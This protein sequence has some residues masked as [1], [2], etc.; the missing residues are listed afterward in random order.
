MAA[1]SDYQAIVDT[2]WEIIYR[3]L[4]TIKKTGTKVNF[5]SEIWWLSG[6]L[7][8]IFSLVVMLSQ[9]I[10]GGLFRLLMEWSNQLTPTF[11]GSI[12]I[13]VG[14]L[15]RSKLVVKLRVSWGKDMHITP[16]LG[17]KTVHQ[18]SWGV[19]MVPSW[20]QNGQVGMVKLSPEGVPL[21]W[22][23]WY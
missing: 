16:L 1:V 12:T 13:L 6:S 15:R 4:E 22:N 14:H 2:E 10:C 7:I 17:C 18:G 3:K 5:L 11:L 20:L 23:H 19:C 21:R 8:M 9:A